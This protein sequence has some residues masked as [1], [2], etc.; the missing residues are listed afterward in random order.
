[1]T[2]PTLELTDSPDED[3]ECDLREPRLDA[4]DERAL[5][6]V[7][8]YFENAQGRYRPVRSP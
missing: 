2:G 3:F 5:A 4:T 6:D 1:V 8:E 7:R